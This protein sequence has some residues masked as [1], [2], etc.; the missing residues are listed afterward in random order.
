MIAL[1]LISLANNDE[2]KAQLQVVTDSIQALKADWFH[3]PASKHGSPIDDRTEDGNVKASST[4]LVGRSGEAEGERTTANAPWNP[5]LGSILSG[6]LHG[7]SSNITESSFSG[8]SGVKFCYT[9]NEKLREAT[10]LPAHC[11][12]TWV[13]VGEVILLCWQKNLSTGGCASPF[14][15]D[16]IRFFFGVIDSEGVPTE[17]EIVQARKKV[18]TAVKNLTNDMLAMHCFEISAPS[19]A[20]ITGFVSKDNLENWDG[21]ASKCQKMSVRHDDVTCM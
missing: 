3:P 16:G 18:L 11:V 21:F 2:L 10:P 8:D 1:L 12:Q 14:R 13:D 6:A 20:K 17:T 4:G 15:K 5:L 9:A 7:S 19:G